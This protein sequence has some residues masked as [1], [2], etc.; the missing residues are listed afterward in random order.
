MRGDAQ[1]IAAWLREARAGSRE[2]LGKLFDLCH[3][4]LLS[5]ARGELDPHLQAKG[6]ASDVLQETFLEAQ[7]DFAGFRG[8]TDKELLAWLR[9]LLLNNLSNFSRDYREAAKRS[10]EREVP[11]DNGSAGA[12][13]AVPS[14]SLSPS[15]HA[16][17]GEQREALERVLQRLPADYQ[18]V[19]RLRYQEELS[20]T[21][22]AA[23][24]QRSSNA[25]RKL[26]LRA[27]EQVRKEM[28]PPP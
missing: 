24:M 28:A 9:R 7:R 8:S 11:L 5:V 16:L 15:A 4:Y 17:A 2:S 26:W 10:I 12:A 23:L 19:I 18:E 25:V 3:G 1:E 27:V 22:I 14:D 6:G 13:E 21:E 20:F